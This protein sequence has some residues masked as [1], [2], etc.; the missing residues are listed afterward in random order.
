MQRKHTHLG[1][2]WHL[3][4][5]KYTVPSVLSRM[6]NIY[7]SFIIK[8]H[9]ILNHPQCF[10]NRKSRHRPPTPKPKNM[11]L[12]TLKQHYTQGK[13][14]PPYPTKKKKKTKLETTPA[15]RKIN[16]EPTNPPF[17]KENDRNQTSMIM[18][19]VNLQGCSSHPSSPQSDLNPT[20]QRLQDL[21]WPHF[22]PTGAQLPSGFGS[23]NPGVKN[24]NT[25]VEWR[26][27]IKISKSLEMK[28]KR[29]IFFGKERPVT[30]HWSWYFEIFVF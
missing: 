6:Y 22:A 30:Y 13:N 25:V 28:S 12:K 24:E 5:H 27:W 2:W 20:S 15:L 29:V 3:S 17:G 11:F 19:P 10:F 7:I 1:F 16:M 9:I 26:K 8:K 18:F 23:K 21:R 4:T 14:Q